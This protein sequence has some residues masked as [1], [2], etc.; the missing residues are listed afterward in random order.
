MAL[1]REP[2][3]QSLY[4]LVRGFPDPDLLPDPTLIHFNPA[5]AAQYFS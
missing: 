5:D 4:G 3:D 2:F 1:V